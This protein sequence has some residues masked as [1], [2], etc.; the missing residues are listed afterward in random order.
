MRAYRGYQLTNAAAQL[1]DI[2]RF[3]RYEAIRLDKNVSC[4]I[5]PSPSDP[6]MTSAWADTNG[7][8][9]L[10]ATEKTILLGNAGN[11]TSSGSVPGASALLT[12][13]SISSGA[14]VIASPSG[15][16]V[17]FDA[18]GAVF[19]PNPNVFYLNSSV[20]PEAGY[21]GVVLMP[22]G[23]VQIWRSDGAGNWQLLR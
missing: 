12:A 19:P 14:T 17:K 23:S 2:L 16:N 10:D 8:N 7:N 1:T 3:T 5:Q 21:R 15:A 13:A 22:A 18:R 9:A 20:S 4:V 6:T 11:L